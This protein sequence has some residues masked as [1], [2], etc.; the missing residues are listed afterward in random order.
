MDGRSGG[1][2]ADE[3]AMLLHYLQLGREALLWKLDGLSENDARLPMTSTGTNV[4]G[5]VKHV[6]GTEAEYLGLVFGRPFA[7]PLPWMEEEAGPNAD[8]FATAQESPADVS[9]LYRRVWAHSD[10]TVSALDLGT[11]GQVPWWSS[12]ANPVTLNRMLVHVIA[13]THRHAGHVDVVR[14]QLDGVAGMRPQALNLPDGAETFWHDYR[15]RL[16]GIAETVK[17]ASEPQ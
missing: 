10:A 15:E 9:G 4:L 17:R 2:G 16:Q 13:E 7:E 11:L 6:A 1:T 8:M 14:E 3:K 12:S 5:V